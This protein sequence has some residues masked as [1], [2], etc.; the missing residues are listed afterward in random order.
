MNELAIFLAALDIADQTERAAYLERTCADDPALR[1][2]VDALLAAHQRS[3]EFLNVP[4]LKQIAA[5][6]SAPSPGV[7]PAVPGAQ[8]GA[9]QQ[10]ARGEKPVVDQLAAAPEHPDATQELPS[11]AGPSA[12][13]PGRPGP[14]LP[15][16]EG[17]GSGA[18]DSDLEFLQPS[19]RPDSLGRLGHYE[20]LQVL[21]K[22]GFGIVFR[23]FDEQLQRVVAIKVLAPEMAATSPARKRFLREARSSAKVRH[24][25]VVQVYA[26]EEEPLP[27][28]VMEFVP[29]ETLQQ[30]IDRTGPLEVTEVVQLGRQ[31]AEG[32]A[33]AH[34][35]GLIHRDIKPGNI[36]LEAGPHPHARITD[37]GLAR[38]ADDASLTQSGVVAG[39]PLYMAPEQASADTL[40]HRA[41]LFSLGS[42][43]YV[44]CS[45]RPPFRAPTTLAVLK[46][47]A[48][49][50]PRPIREIIPEVPQWLC[51][52]ISRLH[53]KKPDDRFATAREVADLLGRGL[54]EMQH[55]GSVKPPAVAAP[56]APKTPPAQQTP[57]AAPTIKPR[58]GSRRWLGAAAMLLVLL[59][60]FSLTEATGVT[61]VRGTVIRLFSPE[62]TLVVEVDD[63][64]VSIK[65]D[66]SDLVI[67]GAG[68]KEIRLKP[69]R[70]VVEASKDGKLVSRELVAVTNNGRQV[71]RV[72]QEAG[73]VATEKDSVAE[74]TDPDRRAAEY[75]LSIGGR[76][77]VDGGREIKAVA[78]LPQGTFR[79]TGVELADNKQVT[80]V[81]LADFK[82]CKG[83]AALSLARTG[84]RISDAG[85]AH[86]KDCKGLTVLDLRVTGVGDAGLAHFK[87]CK[88][89]TVLDLRHTRVTD[90]GLADF[91][92]CKGLTILNLGNA[93]QVSDAGLAHFKDCKTLQTLDLAATEVSDAGLLYFKDCKGLTALRLDFT[94]VGDEGL[95]QFKDCKDLTWLTLKKT[96][97]T[98]AKFEELK[99]V[100]PQ[101]K[102]EWDGG[103]IEPT[104]SLDP[105]RRAAEYVL[106][107]GGAV[108]VN[109]AGQE[110]K[111]AA[112]LPRESFRLTSIN[113]WQKQTTAAGL[114]VFKDCKNLKEL[115][116][117]R[118][119]VTDAGLAHFKDCK[120]LTFLNLTGT[121]VTDAGLAAFK[122]CKNLRRLNLSDTPI[123]DAGLAQFKDNHHLTELWLYFT[124]VTGEGLGAFKGCKDLTFLNL[125]G[126][127]ATDAALA[128]LKDFKNLA[129]LSLAESQVTDVGLAHLKDCT[130]LISLELKGRKVGSTKVSAAGIEEL[131]KALPKCK[132]EWDGGVIEPK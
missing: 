113:L 87:D 78:E 65:I 42:V 117:H 97:V 52:L 83:L 43:L 23:A 37:F 32:L 119:N 25:N 66:G 107:I 49:D 13:P 36:L 6:A 45:G 68:A 80:D 54:A 28:L 128:Q 98:A 84:N 69:G 18:D 123:T 26:V 12:V 9:E 1:R 131:K 55:P 29:G 114:A 34:D 11:T 50:T 46:R 103:V 53:A 7:N 82:G 57:E 76:I 27:Y 63:P 75:V 90:A 59:G 31:I 10:V 22:G 71:V 127:Q 125:Y 35:Q 56:A 81:G 3:G 120:D 16:T 67:T 74:A 110:I 48:E 61:N 38:A 2:Q 101:C 79:L 122:D 112:D 111:A 86:F 33:A 96:K 126:T 130:S 47:V 108:K 8:T 102:I 118:S 91:K 19:S 58:L 89:L 17:E 77:R 24:E 4:A 20:V 51:D 132:I 15:R 92:D 41:D 94:Q 88:G 115:E 105:D 40:D 44:M 64:G 21:G 5:G 121:P 14:S 104:A 106:S 129:R 99:K 85:L 124:R 95:T 100:L 62:G 70:Y 60:G 116:L 39:T 73:P 72:S 93:R 109:E 30:R